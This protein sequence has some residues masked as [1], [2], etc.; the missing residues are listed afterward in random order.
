MMVFAIIL[1]SSCA[2]IAGALWGIY[3]PPSARVE[4]FVVAMAGGALI[5]SAIAELLEPA[6]QSTG[7]W[8][9]LFVF[10]LGA[11][12]FTAIDTWIEKTVGE[13]SGGGLLAAIVLDGIPE[14]LALG[15]VL[16]TAEPAT[17]LALAGS[18]FLSNLPEA[19]GGAR[20]MAE[21][22]FSKLK[23]LGLWSATAAIL[24]LAAIAGNLLLSPIQQ[25]P[26]ALIQ[27]FAAGAVIASLA[28]E[29]F[30]KAYREDNQLAG[31]AVALGVAIAF[32]LHQIGG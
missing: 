3:R 22:G 18:I 21:N 17:V 4:G 15:V 1:V 31:V 25:S 16:I 11:T 6:A 9:L 20:A 26:L 10:G 28:T 7:L 24:S 14:N 8:G 19:A 13:E 30:P 23:T 12:V 29:V 32:T 27:S 2:L 5:V